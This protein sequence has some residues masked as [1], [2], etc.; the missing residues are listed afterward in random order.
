[1]S[2]AMCRVFQQTS[3]KVEVNNA[4][5]EVEKRTDVTTS[6]TPDTYEDYRPERVEVKTVLDPRIEPTR[7]VETGCRPEPVGLVV[8]ADCRP[9]PTSHVEADCRPEHV[10]VEAVL[11]CRPE[12]TRHV[13][14]DCRPEHGEVEAVLDCRPEPIIGFEEFVADNRPELIEVAVALDCRFEPTKVEKFEA[15]LD[16]RAEPVDIP[17]EHHALDY[18]PEP[19]IVTG[20]EIPTTEELHRWPERTID[21]VTMADCRPEPMDMMVDCEATYNQIEPV[22]VHVVHLDV[23]RQPESTVI[24][25]EPGDTA[26]ES[27]MAPCTP[28]GRHNEH[29]TP[30]RLE[31]E[32]IWVVSDGPVTQRRGDVATD[33]SDEVED[34]DVPKLV[35]IADAD[36]AP[37][38][39]ESK[40]LTK[41]LNYSTLPTCILPITAQSDMLD[42]GTISTP[43]PQN[44]S[45]EE[46]PTHTK[47]TLNIGDGNNDLDKAEDEKVR[48]AVNTALLQP[49]HKKTVREENHRIKCF[50]KRCRDLLD[51]PKVL[52]FGIILYLVDVGSDV[53]AGVT[54]FRKGHPV[55]GSLTITFVVLPAICWAAVS[56]TWWYY[57]SKKDKHPMYRRKRMLLCVLLLDPIVR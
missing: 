56:W 32:H 52:I 47:T 39:K 3:G 18:Q 42:S 11:D 30:C 51:I 40:E 17:N 53:T 38:S 29:M 12:P 16:C 7:Q 54:H 36:A 24:P 37:V 21:S 57:D 28:E 22:H 13:E 9:E 14:A 44:T 43:S 49:E 55:W 26:V 33:T 27:K 45:T 35:K 20:Y 19:G 5:E 25:V 31:G 1:M 23:Y 6:D 2:Q 46:D 15:V 48:N 4:A 10:E 41:A 50:L 34:E 8:D